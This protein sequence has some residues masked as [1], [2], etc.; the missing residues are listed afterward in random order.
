MHYFNDIK[1]SH[2]CSTILQF[3]IFKQYCIPPDRF[4][5]IQYNAPFNVFPSS[6]L[7]RQLEE[8]K[9]LVYPLSHGHVQIK[10]LSDIII[11]T[12]PV[13]GHIFDQ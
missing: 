6:Q 13:W 9:M 11:T 1:Q 2:Y 12:E 8:F 3:K 4:C 10:K 5:L 7:L